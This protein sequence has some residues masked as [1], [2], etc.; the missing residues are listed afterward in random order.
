MGYYF[1]ANIKIHDEREYQLYLDGVD[2]VFSRYNGSYLAVDKQP[3]LLEGE[4]GYDRAVV[5]RFNSKKDFLEWYRSDDYKEIL[6]FR[7][8]AAHCDT[9]LV[10]GV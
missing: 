4:W 9:I 1:I 5:I 10:E 2:E 7:L 6:K 3:E 8:K